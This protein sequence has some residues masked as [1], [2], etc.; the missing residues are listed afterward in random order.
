MLGKILGAKLGSEVVFVDGRIVGR[1]ED[2]MLG[3]TLGK[4][5]GRLLGLIVGIMVGTMLGA[6][7]GMALGLTLGI[8]LGWS[9]GVRRII[10]MSTSLVRMTSRMES[11]RGPRSSNMFLG[12]QDSLRRSR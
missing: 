5:L 11:R 12:F 6:V 7:L 10:P 1:T 2:N 8:R 3:C 4:R 9:L